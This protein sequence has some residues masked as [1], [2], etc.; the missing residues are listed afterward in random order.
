MSKLPMQF[1]DF[2]CHYYTYKDGVPLFYLELVENTPKLW[3]I[4]L[5]QVLHQSK[6]CF[7]ISEVW[8]S[9]WHISFLNMKH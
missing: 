7:N 4:I 2:E 9:H 3:N 1:E 8:R 6:D 5:Y